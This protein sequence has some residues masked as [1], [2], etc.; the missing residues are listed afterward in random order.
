MRRNQKIVF[1]IKDIINSRR[2]QAIC[3][4]TVTM[5][6]TVLAAIDSGKSCGT[7]VVIFLPLKFEKAI[8]FLVSSDPIQY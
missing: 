1:P 7:G 6:V 4:D 2:S 5:T 3:R 8:D